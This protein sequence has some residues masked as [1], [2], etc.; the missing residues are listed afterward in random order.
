MTSAGAPRRKRAAGKAE[1]L[2]RPRR[3]R[4]QQRHELDLAAVDEAQAG[5][6]HGFEPDRARAASAKGRRLVSTSCGL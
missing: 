2:G 1:Q 5:G 3:H 6:E 4:A